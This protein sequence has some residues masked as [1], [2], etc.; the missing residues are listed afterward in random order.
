MPARRP[1]W[2]QHRAPTLAAWLTLTTLGAG[3]CAAPELPDT[4]TPAEGE[5]EGAEGEGEGAEGEGEGA[6]GEGEGAEGEG[7]GAEGEGEGAEGEGEG[8][9]GEGGEGEGEP[10]C[11]DADGDGYFVGPACLGVQDCDD[12]D[13]EVNAGADDWCNGRDDDCDGEFDEDGEL[14]PAPCAGVMECYADCLNAG[15]GSDFCWLACTQRASTDAC[16][17]CEEAMMA[18]G[19]EHGCFPR[20]EWDDACMSAHC[21]GASQ[22]CYG[23]FPSAGVCAAD[24]LPCSDACGDE[25]CTTRCYYQASFSCR[26]CLDE[27]SGCML[28]HGCFDAGA[29]LEAC[30]ALHC[31]EP[32]DRCF[33]GSAA[34]TGCTDE[35]GDGFGPGCD[36]PA[37]CDDARA[38]VYPGAPEVCD[39]RD[40]DCDG[41]VDE[42]LPDCAILREWAVLVYLAADNDLTNSALFDLEMLAAAGGS[43]ERVGV[44]VQ[45]ELAAGQSAFGDLLPA[46]AYERTWRLVVPAQQQPSLPALLAAA[47]S[48]GDMDVTTPDA[49][50]SFLDWAAVTV[51]ARRT[52]LVLWDHGGGWQGALADDGSGS[53]MTLGR[54]QQGLDRALVR[55]E[56]V[57]FNACEMAALETLDALEGRT[58]FLVASEDVSGGGSGLDHLLAG[59]RADPSPEP[60]AAATLALHSIAEGNLRSGMHAT[61]TAFDLQGVAPLREALFALTGLLVRHAADLRPLLTELVPASESMMVPETR[62]LA[63]FAGRLRATG[64]PEVDAAAARVV[65]R[66]LDPG[67]VVASRFAPAGSDYGRQDVTRLHGVSVYLPTAAQTTA[68]TLAD[69][70]TVP[71]SLRAGDGWDEFLASFFEDAALGHTRGD[72]RFELSWAAPSGGDLDPAT[73]DLDLLVATPVAWTAPYLGPMDGLALS[74]DSLQTGE[75]REWLEVGTDAAAGSYFVFV[76]YPD[77]GVGGPSVEATVRFTDDRFADNDVLVSRE[78]SLERRCPLGEGFLGLDVTSG[79][80]SNLWFVGKLVRDDRQH[81]LVPGLYDDFGLTPWPT[82]VP[83]VHLPRP[84][85]R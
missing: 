48:V 30:L 58:D 55:P 33:V 65:D 15:T 79:A 8:A 83:L 53:I 51:P 73:V 1:P 74:L 60:R 7:E 12:A 67:L 16:N 5:G 20:G 81:T 23:T 35:D 68:A 41:Q 29:N 10:G 25:A 62:D 18:C 31:G 85:A 46:E 70:G 77:T 11:Q 52:L 37:D 36:G 14:C 82:L 69:Y 2:W 13:P 32:Y 22:H 63:D 57:A 43:D 56:V 6:E 72:F 47:H 84:P 21:P 3:G 9:E 50:A 39:G 66:V 24:F 38:E 40:D 26:G 49:L 64:L 34:S 75:A 61:W 80:C 59:L 78:L 44:A 27:Y 42:K 17:A 45:L 4:A 76:V 19:E 71:L 54:L 28:S